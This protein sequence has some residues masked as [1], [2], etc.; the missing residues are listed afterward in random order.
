MG[1]LQGADIDTQDVPPHG[2]LLTISYIDLDPLNTVMG[3]ETIDRVY[4]IDGSG[5]GEVDVV[6][7]VALPEPGAMQAIAFGIIALGII[8]RRSRSRS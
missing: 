3:I 5:N 1:G 7:V 2:N 6:D 8:G 4:V